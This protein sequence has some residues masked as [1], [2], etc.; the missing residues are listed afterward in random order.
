MSTDKTTVVS[1][2]LTILIVSIARKARNSASN[3]ELLVHGVVINSNDDVMTRTTSW[4]DD[5]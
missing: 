1:A 2:T 3:G 5:M 4:Y